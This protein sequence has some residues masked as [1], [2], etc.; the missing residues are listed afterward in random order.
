M[1]RVV[2]ILATIFS[3]IG[4]ID[5]LSHF[6]SYHRVG[7]YITHNYTAADIVI[8]IAMTAILGMG[9]AGIVMANDKSKAPLILGCGIAILILTAGFDLLGYLLLSYHFAD[10]YIWGIPLG[11]IYITGAANRK[12]APA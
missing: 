10:S 11:V 2:G 8:L 3:A 4:I 6:E 5:A 7:H 9:I 1:I 12:T